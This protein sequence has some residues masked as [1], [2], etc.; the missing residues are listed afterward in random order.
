ALSRTLAACGP[1]IFV[2]ED[3]HWADEATL[4]VLRLLA[5]RV[6]SVPALIVVT[7]RDELDRSHPLRIVLGEL[8]TNGA[9]RRLKLAPLSR[10]AVE[11]LAEPHEVDA[12]ELYDK[13]GG[14]PFFVVEALA[15]EGSIAANRKIELHRKALAVL[16]APPGGAVDSARLAHHAEAAGD[17]EAVL[18]FAPAAGALAASRGAYRE[19]AAQYARAL[20][21]GGHLTLAERADLLEQRSYACYLTDQNDAAIAAAEERVACRRE[22]GDELGEG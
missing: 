22:L 15:V 11:T 2:L 10:D 1:S 18:R 13:T 21:F 3:V 20:R 7:Y 16:A 14:N 12:Y 6:E 9:V 4:D 5:R 8:A 17:G 19:A